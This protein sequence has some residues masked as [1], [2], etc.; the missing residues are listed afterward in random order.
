MEELSSYALEMRNF[1][2]FWLSAMVEQV[3]ASHPLSVLLSESGL[4]SISWCTTITLS[5]SKKWVG[6]LQQS[7]LCQGVWSIDSDFIGG[8]PPVAMVS[9]D[10]SPLACGKHLRIYN[11]PTMAVKLTTPIT[12]P[13]LLSALCSTRLLQAI[14]VC[15][16]ATP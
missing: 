6:K 9:T 5:E 8:R 1:Q 11:L 13:D 15:T 4:Q 12:T 3:A 10:S 14:I 2:D 7:F 16:F